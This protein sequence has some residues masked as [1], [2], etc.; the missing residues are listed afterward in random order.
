MYIKK[1]Y[2]NG[3]LDTHQRVLLIPNQAHRPL[4]GTEVTEYTGCRPMLIL[5]VRSSLTP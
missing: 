2:C 4:N 5:Q 1:V 3:M